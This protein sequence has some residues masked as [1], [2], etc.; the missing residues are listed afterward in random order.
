MHIYFV[1]DSKGNSKADV[2]LL[3]YNTGAKQS[4][5]NIDDRLDGD[6]KGASKNIVNSFQKAY[7]HLQHSISCSDNHVDIGSISSRVDG[8]FVKQQQY[9]SD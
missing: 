2:Q 3:M 1:Y 6:K 7:S 5:N 8:A 4:T 9:Q